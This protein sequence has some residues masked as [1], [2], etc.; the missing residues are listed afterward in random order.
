[1]ISP[2]KDIIRAEDEF[3]I[4]ATSA[5]AD[6]R[7]RVLKHG[8]TFA[9]FD[10]HGDIQPVGLGEQGLYHEGT[11]FLSRMELLLWESRPLLL[12]SL[13]TE[14]NTLFSV[15]FANPDVYVDGSVILPRNT[16]RI[17]RSKF[18]WNGTCYERLWIQN[19]APH[20]VEVSFTVHFEADFKD[21]FE[22]RGLK[23]RRR[24]R[25]LR[26][27]LESRGVCL[28]YQGLDGTTRR[29]LIR[30]SPRPKKMGASRLDFVSRL[31]PKGEANFYLSMTCETKPR[32]QRRVDFSQ[33]ISGIRRAL[34]G[35]GDSRCEVHTSNKKFNDWLN[36]S[37][38]D[39][40]MMITETPYGPY[41]YSGVPWFNTVFGRD[42]IITAM[43][44]LWMNPSLA[45]GVLGYLAAHQATEVDP[46]KDAEPGKIL[47]EVRK[48]E[49]AALGEIPFGR[50][51]GSVDATPLFVLL[52]GMYYERTGDL[53][54][55]KSIWTNIER[56]LN[57]IDT[58]G[59]TDGDG[60][61]EY[62]KRA[63]DGLIHQGWKDSHDSVFHTDGRDATGAIALCEV[64]A[65]VYEAKLRAAKLAEALGYSEKASELT[66]QA[67]ALRRRFERAF[68]C[69]KRST[70][71]LALGGEK[72]PCRVRTSN[73]GHCLFAGIANQ[74]H[75]KK[76]ATTLLNPDSFS[77]WGIRT[78]AAT[79]V[80][81]NPMS[82]HNGSIWP[83]DNAM[84]AYGLARYGFKEHALKILTGLFDASI[85]V[86][87]H[88][89]PELFC[90]FTR[91]RGEGL[92]IYP[93]ACVPQSWA[94]A[95]VFMCLQ[96]CLG[97]SI[98]ASPPRITFYRPILPEYL[99][100]IVI[101]NLSVGRASADLVLHCHPQ[102]V[103]LKIIRRRGNVDVIVVK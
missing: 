96:A 21:I 28:A 74:Q 63:H 41:P 85:F 100:E 13:V 20:A 18:L 46:K 102:D 101:K 90:G 98:S 70:Y 99:Q 97:L 8:D 76:I 69:E 44:V 66:L 25:Y 45:K 75:A 56:A 14:D 51:Y 11:R 34:R 35:A 30:S 80:R 42:G 83:H 58:R 93:L 39:L 9:V 50:Y 31:R 24:G 87:L 60:F 62:S 77:G 78:V 52:A 49:M 1:M 16:I 54:F 88:R 6:D 81:Y 4:L 7:T 61:V 82:Y 91:R 57:W 32:R 29:T 26:P 95:S 43:E 19:F 71:A 3:Y 67:R 22:I 103:G 64:Q 23:R 48:G 33:A 36:R 84:I 37:T 10:R 72:R 5:L 86:E 53:N 89:L 17:V 12:N 40:R 65:Y 47:H 55:I 79:E 15:D 94:A 59:D 68:W 38:A 2:K 92:T 73:A 27:T